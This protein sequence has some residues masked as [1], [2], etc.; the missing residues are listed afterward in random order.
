MS[1]Q[2]TGRSGPSPSPAAAILAILAAVAVSC[3]GPSDS[4]HNTGR[5]SA[6]IL[7][8]IDTLRADRLGCY[9]SETARTPAIDALARESV[10]Y[11][12]ASTVAPVTLVAHATILTGL[13]PPAHG[14]RTNGSFRLPG[15]VVTLAER[16]SGLGWSAGAFVGAFVLH[17][18][19]GLDQGFGT[20]DD[21]MPR[22]EAGRKF[23]YQERRAGEVLA[24]A[25]AWALE[26]KGAP[27]FLWAHVFDPHAPYDPPA[28][29]NAQ[30]ADR[31]YEGEIAYVDAELGRFFSRLREGG[32]LDRALVIVASDH[33]EALGEHG[34]ST[35]GLLL[36]QGTM[37][38]PLIVRPPGGLNAP[39]RIAE[40][41]GLI[42][43]APTVLAS[44]GEFSPEAFEGNPL[45]GLPWAASG[46]ARRPDPPEYYLENL[47]PRFSF[48]WAE[49]TGYRQGTKKI[50]SSRRTELFDL[51]RDPGE[52]TDLSAADGAGAALM[53]ARLQEARRSAEAR[54]T[55]EAANPDLSVE[56]REKLLA[57]GYISGAVTERAPDS[58][59]PD[60]R[61]RLAYF[62]GIERAKDLLRAGDAEA[63]IEELRALDR[64]GPASLAVLNL[65]GQALMERGRIEPALEVLERARSLDPRDYEIRRR[66]AEARYAMGEY[67]RAVA[68]AREALRLN[69]RN[70][71]SRSVLGASLARLGRHDEAV[72]AFREAAA[73]RPEEPALAYNLGLALEEA[74]RTAEAES[75]FAAAARL[76]PSSAAARIALGRL[77][78]ARGDRA[79]AVRWLDEAV[80][81]EPDDPLARERLGIAMAQ[82]GDAAGALTQFDRVV[83]L[84]PSRAE[85]HYDRALVLETL[86]RKEEAVDALG[87]F[88]ALWKGDPS[89]IAEARS[90]IA[91]L[92]TQSGRGF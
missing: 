54:R 51:A 31:P 58:T 14:V 32:I 63:G 69:D 34:E 85:G 9:G 22:P 61:D 79:A 73:Q 91:R 28:P 82:S 60:P 70:A 78:S 76:D 10:L 35:H 47:M 50:V 27:F 25:G 18:E 84:D 16:L 43:V 75:A 56:A 83:A 74:G 24:R 72:A 23:D 87:R 12:D 21:V 39:S 66:L 6:V 7:V 57:L 20:Y 48:G 53:G 5:P 26:R 3:R 55:G 90:R 45:P 89:K 92:K 17:H 67:E 86:G 36:Y 44:L 88:I 46:T 37:R 2:R 71:E 42:D 65:L 4:P 30:F 68:E 8:T 40:P 19:F 77:S 33:G 11:L 15:D 1:R 41:V 64:S 38:V 52:V 80:A 59:A 29:F 62:A 49:L 13:T 81:I